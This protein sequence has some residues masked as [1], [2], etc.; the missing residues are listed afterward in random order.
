M[1]ASVPVQ[2]NVTQESLSP[3]CVRSNSPRLCAAQVGLS[4]VLLMGALFLCQYQTKSFDTVTITEAIPAASLRESDAHRQ[5]WSQTQRVS[6][7][8]LTTESESC[9]S[10]AGKLEPDLRGTGGTSDILRGR[11]AE[12]YLQ[13]FG[14][15][16]EELCN[17]FTA[18]FGKPD[19]RPSSGCY[20]PRQRGQ[21][22][23][24]LGPSGE[25]WHDWH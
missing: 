15:S 1:L 5:V 7:A 23:G 6:L 2:S 13:F 10:A 17:A 11:V 9:K 20:W 4:V 12:T 19:I 18:K 24:Y 8:E 16:V 25:R 3:H 21:L 14:D 22:S